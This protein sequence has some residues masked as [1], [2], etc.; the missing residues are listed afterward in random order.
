MGTIRIYLALGVSLG[1]LGCGGEYARLVA[2]VK[3]QD[4]DAPVLADSLAGR[5]LV[6]QG[7]LVKL[8]LRQGEQEFGPG[9]SLPTGKR[10]FQIIVET[11][12]EAAPGASIH[13]VEL[14]RNGEVVLTQK[15]TPGQIVLRFGVE[16]VVEKSACSYQ[17]RVVQRF[18]RGEERTREAWTNPVFVGR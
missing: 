10:P 1:L 2:Q 9:D 16:G 5:V 14:V 17:A 3:S 13:E 15:G 8:R 11:Y 18:D 4:S 6:S 12:A 7:P